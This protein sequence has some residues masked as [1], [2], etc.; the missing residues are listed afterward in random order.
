MFP[1][2]AS[3]EEKEGPFMKNVFLCLV[4]SLTLGIV[5]PWVRGVFADEY[6]RGKSI[7]ED[8]CQICHGIK[9]KGDG[10]ASAAFKPRPTDFTNPNFWQGDVNKNIVDTIRKGRRPM[11]AFQMSDDEIKAVTDYMSHTFKNTK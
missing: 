11:P 2:K 7:Y 8:K 10:P 1:A 9:G 6:N 5:S 3:C 4:V